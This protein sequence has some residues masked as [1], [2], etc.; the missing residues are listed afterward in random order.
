MLRRAACGQPSARPPPLYTG[1][2]VQPMPSI[3]PQRTTHPALRLPPATLLALLLG[4][5]LATLLLACASGSVALGPGQIWQALQG[6]GDALATTLLQLRLERALT[7]WITGAALALA[8]LLMQSLLRNPLAD[9]Y[10]MGVSGGA[11]VG[12]LMALW[13]GLAVWQV[14]LAAVAGALVLSGVL[15]WLA[16]RDF[17]RSSGTVLLL[18]TGALLSTACGAVISLLLTIAQ[19]NQ[20]RGMVFWLV[21]DISGTPLR[22]WPWL[23]LLPAMLLA[24]WQAPAINLLALHGDHAATLGVPLARLRRLLLLL[25]ASLTATAV[26]QG[27]SIGFVGLMVPH[28]CRLVCGP[29]LRLLIPASILSG[30]SL[31]VLADTLART[32]VA[33]M[34]LPV[35]ILTA[36]LGVPVLFWQL[37]RTRRR[38][39]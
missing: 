9:P 34:Q 4:I 6:Q 31:L 17:G 7:A 16:R 2:T 19:D 15:F 18:L 21:G 29:N 39:A 26:S 3:S 1:N 25:S 8:G 30:A 14:D 37:S 13:L 12:A 27:G 20:L 5:S 24:W 10:V 23:V 32:V 11:S 35:G 38:L 28:A 36:L 33:P 22:P